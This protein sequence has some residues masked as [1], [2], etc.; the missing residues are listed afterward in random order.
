M[1]CHGLS[2][3]ALFMLAGSLQER[4][5]TRELRKMGGLWSAVPKM[6]AVGMFFAMASL[7][8]PGLGN[9]VGEFLVLAGTWPQHP[10]I[11][12][13]AA[14][15]LVPATIYSLWIVQRVFHGP[16]REAWTTRDL[17]ARDLTAQA[18]L[19]VGILWLGLY[20]QPVLDRV[21]GALAHL[22]PY[23]SRSWP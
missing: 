16:R 11:A 12:V 22:P 21:T 18:V 19:V 23:A 5:H 7:G 4:L 1:I 13:L 17:S 15:G 6:G 3:G 8:L 10:V 20:P 2:T 9:F 14:V